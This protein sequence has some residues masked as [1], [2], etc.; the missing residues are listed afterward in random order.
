MSSR[1]KRQEA[2]CRNRF[3]LISEL[4]DFVDDLVVLLSQVLVEAV[5]GADHARVVL[6]EA[7]AG[8]TL[9][10]VQLVVRQEDVARL[11]VQVTQVHRVDVPERRPVGDSVSGDYT[12]NY[13]LGNL[14]P[15]RSDSIFASTM[16]PKSR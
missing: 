6:G 16:R 10:A 14:C 1:F 3:E 11:Q 7:R 13:S 4:T 5:V 9:A 15:V 8:A 2:I 12:M